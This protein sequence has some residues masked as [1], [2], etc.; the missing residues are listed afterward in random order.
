MAVQLRTLVLANFH[1]IYGGGYRIQNVICSLLY[2]LYRK[3]K[4]HEYNKLLITQLPALAVCKCL[5]A[6]RRRDQI[7]M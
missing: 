7:V 5:K 1:W 2:I 6:C 4:G 3:H